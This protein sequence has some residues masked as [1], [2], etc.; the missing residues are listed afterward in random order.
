MVLSD[1][2][3]RW[4]GNSHRWHAGGTARC[5]PGFRS[6]ADRP[7]RQA[8]AGHPLHHRRHFFK[9][10]TR[11]PHLANQCKK[12]SRGRSSGSRTA[13][14]LRRGRALCVDRP[15]DGQLERESAA[16][17]YFVGCKYFTK[18][19]ATSARCTAGHHLS[20]E[21]ADAFHQ[22]AATGRD[23]AGGLA[24]RPGAMPELLLTAGPGA[25]TIIIP[26][27]ITFTPGGFYQLWLV[28]VNSKGR[29]GAGPNQNWTA[30]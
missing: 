21:H 27:T 23:P 5:D 26:A 16:G 20:A 4:P 17:R 2:A 25:T 12:R 8:S 28:G 3:A 1:A 29:S 22:R 15:R 10:R 7:N 18:C 19:A 6:A 24:R 9:R 13:P 14:H 30:P 11:A